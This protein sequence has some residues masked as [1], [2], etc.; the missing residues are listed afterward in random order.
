MK[1]QRNSSFQRVLSMLTQRR[2]ISEVSRQSLRRFPDFFATEQLVVNTSESSC[3]E[4]LSRERARDQGRRSCRRQ[5]TNE[6]EHKLVWDVCSDEWPYGGEECR[7]RYRIIK[8]STA[9]AFQ[10]IRMWLIIVSKLWT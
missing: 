3:N 8:P 4:A 2:E 1:P 6:R 10:Y 7:N 9:C 5:Y